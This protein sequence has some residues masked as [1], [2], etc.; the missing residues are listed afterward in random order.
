MIEHQFPVGPAT[1]RTQR[2]YTSEKTRL[3]TTVI[4]MS[5]LILTKK[6]I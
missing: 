5:T 6:V 3:L 4:Q 1:I 2:K